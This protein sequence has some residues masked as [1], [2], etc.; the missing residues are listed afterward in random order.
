MLIKKDL[1]S[2]A[3]FKFSI[4]VPAIP[5]EFDTLRRAIGKE[6]SKER[7]KARACSVKFSITVPAVRLVAEEFGALRL[8]IKEVSKERVKARARFVNEPLSAKLGSL[9]KPRRVT[10]LSAISPLRIKFTSV[11]ITDAASTNT[12][13]WCCGSSRAS[14][15]CSRASLA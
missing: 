9:S 4:T 10:T 11:W 13:D 1:G 8:A 12:S 2:F 14:L 3:T 15:A 5:E 7:A 6:V